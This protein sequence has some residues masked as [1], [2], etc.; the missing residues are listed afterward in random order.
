MAAILVVCTGNVCRSPAAEGFLRRALVA[1]LGDDAPSVSSAGTAGWEGSGATT[2]SVRASAERGVDTGAHR[3]RVLTRS[4]IADADLVVGMASE[5][6][7]QVVA[8]VPGAADRTFTLKELV[9]LLEA[10]PAAGGGLGD[11]VAGAA[12]RRAAGF[13][14]NPHDEDVADPLGMSYDAYRAMAWELEEW[15]DRLVDALVA[16]G[17]SSSGAA[18]AS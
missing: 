14:G 6:G 17:G 15:C 3:A 4:Q 9:R 10:A 13:E 2:E 18:E 1:R 7:D 5:H 8:L 12:A 11:V 16:P